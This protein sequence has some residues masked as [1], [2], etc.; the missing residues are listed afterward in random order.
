MLRD[1]AKVMGYLLIV[2][3]SVVLCT[4]VG[5]EFRQI[6]SVTVFTSFIAGSLFYWPFRN[7]FALA[8]VALLLGLRV[9]DVEH[10]IEFANLDIILFL[11]GMMIVVGYLE[12][13]RF[14]DWL[15]GV[16]TK[17]FCS[18]PTALIAILL[19]LA[20]VMAALVDEVTSILFMMAIMLRVLKAFGVDK[21]K[22][23]PFIIFLVFTTNIGS[24]AL[25]VGNPIGVMVAFRAGLTT[26]DFVRWVSP[27]AVI[28]AA[29]VTLIGLPYLKKTGFSEVKVASCADLRIEEVKFTREMLLPLMVFIAVLCGLIMHHNIEK[30]LH[31]PKSTMLLATPLLGAGAALFIHRRRARE[32]VEKKVDWWTL[33]YFILLFSSV[34]TLKYT[35]VTDLIAQG[36]LHIIGGNVFYA[37]LLIGGISGILTAF[38]DNVLAIATMIPV[39]QSMAEAGVYVYPIWW[40]MLI[41]GT[42]CGNATVIGSTA[43]IVAAGFVEKRGYGSFSMLKWILLGTP[44]SIVTFLLALAMLYLQIPA[45]PR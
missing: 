30:A 5:L 15:I 12:E 39:V 42:Y 10:L 20:A 28:N 27:L 45:M 29:V 22:V 44:I 25:P 6:I 35:G 11:I 33:L 2:A 19:M 38:M 36:V 7:A 8:G 34:G 4:A 21:S 43:N 40:I 24:S 26:L 9:L 31:L 32:L 3:S 16:L 23:L 18:R 14:F 37:M 1:F 13:K 17:P 41:G